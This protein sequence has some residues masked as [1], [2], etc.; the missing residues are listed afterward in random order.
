MLSPLHDVILDPGHDRAIHLFL[1]P[2]VQLVTGAHFNQLLQRQ[3][4][5]L[6]VLHH[7][8]EAVLGELFRDPEE[9]SAG[10]R[11]CEGPNAQAVGG[12]QLTFQKLTA[13]VLDLLEL[14]KKG[15][16]KK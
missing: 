10:V 11:V 6:F 5:K 3:E 14:A 1:A 8:L 2:H 12:I 13:H 9:F 15:T 4:Q 16:E 7:L